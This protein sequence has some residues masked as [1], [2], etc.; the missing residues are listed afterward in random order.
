V[1]EQKRSG[2]VKAGN[3]IHNLS[4]M[5][6]TASPVLYLSLIVCVLQFNSM[7]QV[8]AQDGVSKTSS[9]AGVNMASMSMYYDFA[10]QNWQ[11]SD[12]HKILADL[13]F[14]KY[15]ND[16][17]GM[18]LDVF[19]LDGGIIDNGQLCRPV[20]GRSA[21]GTFNSHWVLKRFPNQF[22]NIYELA[23]SFGCKL[24]MY[25]GP[26][27][28][29]NTPEKAQKRIAFLG[30][31]ARN[32]HMAVFKMDACAGKLRPE[33]ESYL[34]EAI[35]KARAFTPGLL[36]LN[37]GVPLSHDLRPYIASTNW[38]GHES[39]VDVNDFNALTGL[40]HR[41]GSMDKPVTPGLSRFLDDK[42]IGLSSSLDAWDDDLILQAFNRN[43]LFAPQIFGNP[44][45]LKDE[46]LP[47][48]AH[49]FNLHKKYNDILVNG[50]I[51]P[52]SQYGENAVSRGNDDTRLITLRNLSW[53][54][55][56]FK[57]K[58]DSTIGIKAEG[59]YM[60]KQLFP[61]EKYIGRFTPENEVEV[62]VQ[63]FRAALFL[64]TQHPSEIDLRGCDYQVLE[65]VSGKPVVIKLLGLPGQ[66]VKLSWGGSELP[67]SQAFL[68]RSLRS[69]FFRKGISFK[70][71]GP[72]FKNPY[73][74]KLGD[75]SSYTVTPALA[76]YLYEG[77][78]FAA[79][80]NALEIRSLDRAGQ[81]TIRTVNLARNAFFLDSSFTKLGLWDK[82]AFDGESNTY[83]STNRVT[84]SKGTEAGG[85]FRLDVGRVEKIDQVVFESVTPDFDPRQ[86]E[87]SNDLHSWTTVP[88][89]SIG[90]NLTVNCPANTSFRYLRSLKSPTQVSEI[91]A[92]EHGRLLGR[93]TWRASNLFKILDPGK[94]KNAYRLEFKI[95]KAAPNS[96]LAVSVPGSYEG[97]SVYAALLVDGKVIGAPD[98]SPAYPYNNWVDFGSGKG[99]YTFY[100]PFSKSML[101]KNLEVVVVGTDDRSARLT[102]EA[103]MTTT[104]PPYNE[105]LLVLK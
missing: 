91:K 39:Y 10:N 47:R 40:N 46:E 86:V 70:F 38:E 100:F 2:A 27:G 104:K 84:S 50:K 44:W 56:K 95:R 6:L 69:T 96:L 20:P 57:I 68:N 54:P 48:L 14:F 26:D 60:A 13:E 97:E 3:L 7:S 66:K 83:F 85:G 9:S 4:Y 94:V 74:R 62:E 80:N 75:L 11:G 82:N 72:K 12:E 24:G 55:R 29:G 28:F 51:L 32:Y 88:A 30:D 8:F 37:D 87:I 73:H 16:T 17:Y 103:W 77:S 93:Q 65:E 45:L 49:I 5:K 71:P 25:I 42:G 98:R 31:L 102:P 92:Y 76:S 90:S 36:V 105:K 41:L 19:L 99:N 79:D 58:I 33:K 101:K 81:S 59:T 35:K 61:T 67:V 15:M 78:C 64:I 1:R 18:K 89:T 34:I 21:Y 52:A 22:H 63:P 23:N 43:T 53:Y